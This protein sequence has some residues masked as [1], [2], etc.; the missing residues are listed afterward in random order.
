MRRRLP[1]LRDSGRL[2]RR[3]CLV[4]YRLHLLREDNSSSS[5]RDGHIIKVVL[6]LLQEENRAAYLHD[7]P[8]GPFP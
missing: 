7:E 5:Y 3:Q 2:G 1:R 8:R 4:Q 6:V